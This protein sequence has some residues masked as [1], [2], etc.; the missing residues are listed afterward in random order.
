M[1]FIAPIVEGQ[2]EQ[3]AVKRLLGRIAFDVSPQ[4]GLRV[5]EPIRIKAGSFL[6][7]GGYFQKYMSLAASKA[8]QQPDG[9]VLILLDCEDDL[10]CRLG[11][12]LLSRARAVAADINTIVALAYREYETW[13]LAAAQ[14]LRDVEGLSA[15]LTCPVRPQAIRDAKGWLG[16]RMPHGY[17]P[18]SHQL[19]LTSR[20]DLTAARTMDSFDRLYRK[21]AALVAA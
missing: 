5:N 13:F 9:H 21:I 16:S 14:S 7:N 1:T 20:F 4:A 12:D 10:P 8:R 15:Q 3:Y 11:P 6:N 2:G 17:D 18:V 19:A